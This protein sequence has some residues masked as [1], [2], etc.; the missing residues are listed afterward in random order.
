M[1]EGMKAT[2]TVEPEGTYL[3]WNCAGLPRKA[4]GQVVNGFLRSLY[5]EEIPEGAVV[6][7]G[8]WDGTTFRRDA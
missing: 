8:R 6:V 7:A 5:A 4:Y 2:W 1:G 3:A